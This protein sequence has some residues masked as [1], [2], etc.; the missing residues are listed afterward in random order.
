LRVLRRRRLER[1]GTGALPAELVIEQPPKN[2]QL[3]ITGAQM[4]DYVYDTED[5][6]RSLGSDRHVRRS[7]KIGIETH[8]V[9]W[10]RSMC[11]YL[12]MDSCSDAMT[13]IRLSQELGT[14]PGVEYRFNLM[15]RMLAWL[16]RDQFVNVF[17]CLNDKIIGFAMLWIEPTTSTCFF[18]HRGFYPEHRRH[19]RWSYLQTAKVVAKRYGMKWINLGDALGTPG[20]AAF[21]FGLKPARL[22]QYLNVLDRMEQLDHER[23]AL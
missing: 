6:I 9:T 20:L 10:E 13:D 15:T 19:M 12:H 5:F 16:P 21:K 22:Q 1:E 18:A 3:Y 23:P 2:G 11:N 4:F 14:P 7:E 17:F 8:V